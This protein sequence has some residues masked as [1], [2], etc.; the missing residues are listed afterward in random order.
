MKSYFYRSFWVR[1]DECNPGQ[2]YGGFA[3]TII[4]DWRWGTDFK[5]ALVSNAYI[6]NLIADTLAEIPIITG[7]KKLIPNSEVVFL[8]DRIKLTADSVNW[9]SLTETYKYAVVL[10][11]DW[12]G[13]VPISLVDFE[14]VIA[15]ESFTLEWENGAVFT[16]GGD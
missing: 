15:D 9:S 2:V 10:F 14:Q 11:D 13:S 5:I 12:G 6:P 8:N 4:D 16:F 7:T 3:S 1:D